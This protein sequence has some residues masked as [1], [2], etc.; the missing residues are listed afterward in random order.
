M[1][2]G[3]PSLWQRPYRGFPHFLEH[4]AFS[5]LYAGMVALPERAKTTTARGETTETLS[6][7]KDSSELR[8]ERQAGSPTVRSPAAADVLLG[9]V[10]NLCAGLF[11]VLSDG[12]LSLVDAPTLI[13]RALPEGI[14]EQRGADFR[15]EAATAGR[16]QDSPHRF[17]Q[18]KRFP[19]RCPVFSAVHL[20]AG[21]NQYS[22]IDL[23]GDRVVLDHENSL[24]RIRRV[25]RCRG[26]GFRTGDF[27]MRA[28]L[29]GGV[30]AG[31]WHPAFSCAATSVPQGADPMCR[32]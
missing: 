25:S 29:F 11:H 31:N 15:A 18:L 2:G 8:H 30:L 7:P 13:R 28:H 12:G 26:S 1:R 22:G 27:K 23:A 17:Q 9:P 10:L 4:R 5:Q 19:A 20:V 24:G 14:G 6:R 32:A 21:A 3:C 16:A